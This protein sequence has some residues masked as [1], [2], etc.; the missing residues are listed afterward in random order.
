[1]QILPLTFAIYYGVT[2]IAE[3]RNE[4][5][6]KAILWGRTGTGKNSAGRD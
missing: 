4:Y 5:T 6:G 2:L 3:P 1:M